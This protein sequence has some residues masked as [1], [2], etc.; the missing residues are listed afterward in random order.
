ME[1]KEWLVSRPCDSIVIV[2]RY[3]PTATLLELLPHLAPS[4]PFVV[5][6][7][8]IE[9][10]AEC[11]RELQRQ[12]LA[13]NIRLSDTWMREY[14]VL[15]GRTHPSMNM[16]QSGGYI[17]TGIKLCPVTGQNELDD[18]LLKELKES[19]GNSRRG[20]KGK[21]KK[22]GKNTQPGKRNRDDDDNDSEA[23]RGTKRAR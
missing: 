21:G 19:V 12:S 23:N 20:K 2:A 10:L 4:C 16:S 13:L 5:Y 1:A 9:P 17:L 15:P 8:Y 18:N 14:Q 7:E 11:F 3:D 22:K 6:H